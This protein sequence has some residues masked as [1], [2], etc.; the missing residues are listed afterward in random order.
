MH[1]SPG[2]SDYYEPENALDGLRQVEEGLGI[3]YNHPT[4]TYTPRGCKNDT[5]LLCAASSD[6]Y[7]IT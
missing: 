5:R 7:S 6:V 2:V 4:S 3:E 1:A